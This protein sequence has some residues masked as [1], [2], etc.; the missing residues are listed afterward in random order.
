MHD[1]IEHLGGTWSYKNLLYFGF[2]ARSFVEVMADSQVGVNC[3]ALCSSLAEMYD[4]QACAWILDE[5][6]KQY[7]FPQEYFPSHSQSTNLV[8]ACSG[9]L[10]KTDF[11]ATPDR[12]LGHAFAPQEPCLVMAEPEDV[13][14]ALRG[15]AGL[16]NGSISQITVTGSVECAFIPSFAQWLLNLTVYV[17]DEFGDMI[18]QNASSEEARVVVTY[19]P[20]SE[21]PLVHVSSTTYALGEGKDVVRR[22]AAVQQTYIFFRTPWDGCLARVFGSAFASLAESS[23]ILDD[24]FGSVARIYGGLAT[25]ESDVGKF[26]RRAYLDYGISSYGD[27]FINSVV[28]TFPELD[29]ISGLFGQMQSAMNVPIKDALRTVERAVLDLAQLCMCQYCTPSRTKSEI[30]C[31]VAVALSIRSIVSIISYTA[32]DEHILPTLHGIEL[33]LGNVRPW[34]VAEN[35]PCRKL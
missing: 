35:S 3:I 32:R 33:V 34:V 12:L 8:K 5:L 15:L 20:I 18:Y 2:G 25:R 24:L 29:R 16:S 30:P 13:A 1:A 14:K 21:L 23:T 4:E 27:G 19:R 10:A 7:G 9:V 17:E 31:K 26:S 6:W 28:S 11:T 22:S